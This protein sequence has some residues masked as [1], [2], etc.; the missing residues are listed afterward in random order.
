MHRTSASIATAALVVL[1]CTF[2]SG[3][4]GTGQATP[5]S[6]HRTDDVP[7]SSS[8]PAA[9]AWA[10]RA[11][12]ICQN[13]LADG[14]HTLVD[15]FDARHVRQHGMA[16]VAAGSK[17]D[18]LGAPAGG[19]SGAYAHMIELYR[20]S[21]IYHGLAVRELAKGNAGNA[22]AEYA[23]GLQFAHKA[24]RLAVGFGAASCGRFGM[25]S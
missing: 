19:D 21:A 15:H 7:A 23:I 10:R 1:S 14:N 12:R 22:A 16:V 8:A 18:A 4:G 24:D 25:N 5:A 6:A 11:S 2:A 17:L 9:T 20:K 13:A 3:C